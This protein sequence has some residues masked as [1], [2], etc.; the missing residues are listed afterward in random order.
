M[1]FEYQHERCLPNTDPKP[2]GYGFAHAGYPNS[3]SD[4]YPNSHTDNH[5]DTNPNG[6]G[7]SDTYSGN[8]N[9][10]ADTDTDTCYSNTHSNS[11][12]VWRNFPAELRWGDSPGAADR[13]DDDHRDRSPTSVGDLGD[14][15]GYGAQ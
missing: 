2:D 12:P 8:T 10:D 9:T 4:S 14:L 7:I 3:N 11:Y 15:T 13:L 1:E 6:H 5:T